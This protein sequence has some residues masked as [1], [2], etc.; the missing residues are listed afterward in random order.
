MKKQKICVIGDGLTGLTTA[1]SIKTSITD[2]DLYCGDSSK[3]KKNDTRTT[4][5]SKSNHDFI[6]NKIG[7]SNKR[8]FWECNKINLYFENK[9]KHSNF[10]NFSEKENLMYI[11]ENKKLKEQLIKKIKSKKI[12]LLRKNVSE[13]NIKENYIKAGSKKKYDLYLLCLGAKSSFYESLTSSRSIKKDYSEIS[14]T[15]N[16]NHNLKING[17][18]QYF[19]KEGPLAILPFKKNY[20]SF[21]WSVSKNFYE[22]NKENLKEK[23]VEKLSE[24]LKSNLFKMS[25][26]QYYPIHLNLQKNYHKN[27]FLILGEGLHSIHPIAGQGFNLVLRDIIELRKIIKKNLDLGF[28]IKDSLALDDFYSARKAENTIF[29]LGVDMTNSFFKTNLISRSMKS[30]ALKE[31][32]K[33]EKLKKITKIISDK[34]FY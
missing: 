2:V 15:A 9:N 23:V 17:P 7:I 5:I 3:F 4:A 31:F 29:S 19:L 6:V 1:L 18:S 25:K 8:L 13:I 34:G 21:V 14:I 20:F 28:L 24:L 30:F 10:L 11:F 16:I 32:N 22:V 33:F 26:I 27:N 12:K